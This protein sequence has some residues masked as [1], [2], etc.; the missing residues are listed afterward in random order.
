[1]LF[2]LVFLIACMSVSACFS[3]VSDEWLKFCKSSK[4]AILERSQ[5][6][7]DTYLIQN[8]VYK[9][10]KKTSVQRTKCVFNKA[11]KLVTLVRGYGSK[12][13]RILHYTYDKDGNLRKI[14][15]PNG[16][17]IYFKYGDRL[18]RISSSD[19]TIDYM[20]KV[21]VNGEG[22]TITQFDRINQQSI[23]SQISKDKGLLKERFINGFTV[24]YSYKEGTNRLQK[25]DFGDLGWVE[26]TYDDET[27]CSITKRYYG[28]GAYAYERR[29]Q[30]FPDELKFQE[31]LICDLGES[32]VIFDQENKQLVRKSP[33]IN[34]SYWL[35]Q[36]DNVVKQE[37]NGK[38]LEYTY[39]DFYH[40]VDLI[41]AYDSMGNPQDAVVND[42]NELEHFRGIDCTYDVCG[43][44]IEK[45]SKDGVEEFK[46]DALNRL[47]EVKNAKY[48]VKFTYDY[49]Y[50]RLSKTVSSDEGTQK[51]VYA[52]NGTIECA[53]FDENGRFK[54]LRICD[55]GIPGDDI[56]S[57]ETPEATYD[58]I[59]GISGN[60]LKLVNVETKEE[61]SF[62]IDPFGVNL[63]KSAYPIPWVFQDTHYDHETNLVYFGRR[64]YD[65]SLLRWTTPDA[66][67]LIGMNFLGPIESM[68]LYC[69]CRNNPLKDVNIMGKL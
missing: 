22:K 3:D 51:E 6:G 50:R 59:Y 55:P 47:I 54:A 19:H 27:K 18:K 53:I 42:L 5:D 36:R 52:Y 28:D 65:P 41:Q 62:K 46:Y 8:E 4:D 37:M 61:L 16:V 21:D 14:Q 44:L 29:V 25:I 17:E 48:H 69:F 34:D 38:I 43:N 64:Y 11:G 31:D 30:L 58:P 23:M 12:Y 9:E 15:K 7:E 63:S 13:P 2:R 66:L 32:V 56:L 60:L 1:M 10:G 67:R 49:L 33:Y 39:D 40:L 20:F 26:N 68:N 35:D 57:I 45:R 24:R